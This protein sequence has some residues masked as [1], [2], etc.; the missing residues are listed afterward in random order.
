MFFENE[1]TGSLALVRL[2]L[3]LLLGLSPVAVTVL[4]KVMLYGRLIAEESALPAQEER[5]TLA[6]EGT[7]EE[8][9]VALAIGI[10]NFRDPRR[11]LENNSK[12]SSF[13]IAGWR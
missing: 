13:S 5:K 3:V 8:F 12:F 2:L 11:L 10:A 1:L 4:I 9:A 6:I 7:L